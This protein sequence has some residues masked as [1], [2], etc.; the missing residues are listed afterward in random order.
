M[1]QRKLPFGVWLFFAI[2]FFK[3]AIMGAMEAFSLLENVFD[4]WRLA[5]AGGICLLYLLLMWKRKR[6]PSPV[7]ISLGV[8]FLVVMGSTLLNAENY[9]E[10]ANY[11]VTIFAFCMLVEMGLREDVDSALD[12]LYYPL[13]VVIW[14]N[15]IL[16]C[17][18]P[19]GVTKGG[20]YSYAYNFMGIDNFLA[21]TMVPYMVLTAIRAVRK[22]GELDLSSYVAIVV[23]CLNLLLDKSATG[24]M[25]M[26]VIALF[27][28]FIYK[29]RLE[30][31]FN[32]LT[33]LTVSLG[34][35]VSIVLLRL[36]NLF[37]WLIEDILGKG[38]SFT[39]RTNIWDIGMEMI[40]E[41]PLLGWGYAKQGKIYRIVKG[42]YYH[43]HNVYLELLMEGGICALAAFLTALGFSVHQLMKYRKEPCARLISAGLMSWAVMTSMEPFLDTNG[44]MLYALFIM[45]YHVKLLITPSTQQL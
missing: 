31:L 18:Y 26:A 22:T 28:L 11:I 32:G 8:Y 5:A 23:C 17:I 3:P 30:L 20:T 38:L 27:L 6:L 13:T 42:K 34:M 7:L 44:L 40:R 19:A 24:V 21:P 14:C 10:T 2:P 43:G 36:Q 33:A 4:L 9:W 1:E 37:A 25:G 12:M 45:G 29:R 35:F 39:G 15:L 41:K 16:E